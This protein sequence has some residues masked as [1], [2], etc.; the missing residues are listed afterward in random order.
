MQTHRG[1]RR[2]GAPTRNR[3]A[4][5]S[6]SVA[7]QI[8]DD[9]APLFLAEVAAKMGHR[10]LLLRNHMPHGGTQL[11][12]ITAGKVRGIKHNMRHRCAFSEFYSPL[13]A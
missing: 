1:K 12:R 6:E 3:C 7:L 13:D 5:F 9:G 2:D 8:L 4:S 11:F 10:R